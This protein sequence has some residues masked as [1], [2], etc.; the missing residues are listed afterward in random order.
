MRHFMQDMNLRNKRSYFLLYAKEIILLVEDDP[1][2]W[3]IIKLVF[4][5]D[6]H[7]VH[8]KLA[9]NKIKTNLT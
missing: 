7:F 8:G 3:E 6:Y 5:S 2:F 4:D 9:F 1:A